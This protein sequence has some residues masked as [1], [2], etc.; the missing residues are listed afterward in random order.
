[1]KDDPVLQVSVQSAELD[2]NDR[3]IDANFKR[4]DV[5]VAF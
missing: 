1:M 4:S 3:D 5:N 2:P